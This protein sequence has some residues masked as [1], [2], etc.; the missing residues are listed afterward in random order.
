[1]A[2]LVRAS[3]FESEGREF[4]S[5]RARQKNQQLSSNPEPDC[6]PE[7]EPWEAPGKR[8]ADLFVNVR[9]A[10]ARYFVCRR[11]R[12][13]A[14]VDRVPPMGDADAGLGRDRRLALF[15]SQGSPPARVRVCGLHGAI[16]ATG[17]AR[18]AARPR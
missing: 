8:Q 1:V 14:G 9:S 10:R 11:A 18:P 15:L 17:M 13:V 7:K 16:R 4:E 5:L 6:F 2:Q 12:R 3:D